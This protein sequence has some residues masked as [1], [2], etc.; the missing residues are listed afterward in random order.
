MSNQALI[1]EV[2]SLG[3]EY[4]GSTELIQTPKDG[5]KID[6]PKILEVQRYAQQIEEKTYILQLIDNHLLLTE[7][8]PFSLEELEAE[9]KPL[10]NNLG[11]I[12]FDGNVSAVKEFLS[13]YTCI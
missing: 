3:F 13:I 2:L 10:M 5:S 4:A 11:H 9:N 8:K 6:N 7:F 1:D 12:D